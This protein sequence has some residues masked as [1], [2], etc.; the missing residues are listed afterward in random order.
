MDRC[1]AVNLCH[2]L[3]AFN[4]ILNQVKVKS[5]IYVAIIFKFFVFI[6]I[7]GERIRV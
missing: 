6:A 5:P 2:T 1:W 3:F 7:E 4:K